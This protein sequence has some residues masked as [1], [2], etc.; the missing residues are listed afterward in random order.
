M[1]KRIAGVG[2]LALLGALAGGQGV[3]RS[4]SG[5]EASWSI[6]P[7]HV[8][9]W[10]SS[11]YIP[12]GLHIGGFEPEIAAAAAAGIQDV[13][14]DCPPDPAR[15]KAIVA[16]LEQK[17]LRYLIS[18][19]S[20]S[21]SA[22]GVLIEPSGNRVT[23]ITSKRT[24]EFRLPG[25]EEA[26]VV[27]AVRRD[28]FIQNTQRVR[29]VK[30][31][32]SVVVDPPNDLDHVALIYPITSSL[33]RLGAWEDF[34][35]HRDAVLTS[36]K[37]AGLGKGLRGIV[38]PVGSFTHPVGP[39]GFVPTGPLFRFEF[40]AY[41]KQRYR[42]P[43]TAMRSWAMAGTEEKTFDQIARLV[44]LW[45]GDRGV[46]SLWDP[47]DDKMY[48]CEMRRSSIWRDLDVVLS[49]A[50]A[51]RAERLIASIRRIADV[52]ILQEWSG[53]AP[54][55]EGAPHGLDGIGTYAAGAT[56]SAVAD[57]CSRAASSLLRW[58]KP[59]WLLATNLDLAG[60]PDRAALAPAAVDDLISIGVRGGF[61][62]TTEPAV[63]SVMAQIAAAKAADASLAQYTVRPFYFPEAATN[64]ALPMRLPGGSWWLPTPTAG[65]RI[66]LGSQ[67]YAYRMD[68]PSGNVLALWMQS[69]RARVKLDMVAPDN[70]LFQAVDGSDPKPKK[71]RG[72][73][74]VDVGELPLIVSGIDEIP[75]PSA[76]Y[77]ELLERFGLLIEEADRRHVDTTEERFLFRD[78]L[79]GY[80]RNP[81]GSYLLLSG[82]YQ[83]LA[84]RL[85]PYN[86]I[87]GES[88]RET[89]F[90]EIVAIPGISNGNALALRTQ[91][92]SAQ[93]E[94]TADYII[95]PRTDAEVEC[96]IAARIPPSARNQLRLVIGGQTMQ[97]EGEPVSGYG[98][99]FAWYSLGK[100]R[101]GKAQIKVSL[102]VR[103]PEGADLAIDAI[104]FY[105]G[106]FRPQGD[107][108]PNAI[109]FP[110]GG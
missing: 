98:P 39:R 18:I 58:T 44:P 41:L 57:S 14:V 37:S 46:S 80:S 21:P 33:A 23:G 79:N 81:G 56:P 35:R 49:T 99:G 97:V 60:A 26:L 8:L 34:D 17:N 68:T 110:T 54:L 48:A 65:T 90:S 108:P 104:L 16:S 107:R 88:V 31:D 55:Y 11:P 25:A 71:V 2:F 78:H 75:I 106:A 61:V 66:D 10:N 4:T 45:S 32:F 93:S 52:P 47:Q 53:W 109:A 7:N 85:A 89:N 86:W 63:K 64:P 83:K 15:M 72:G 38:N 76:A 20:L 22:H 13:L 87:E 1:V 6:N 40:A 59:G 96:W 92:L 69:G 3:Y 24:L 94:Y 5:E 29:S 62:R 19:D 70:A 84:Q 50:E 105:P 28:G 74:E 27:L 9:I 77:A 36:L 51:R 12:F 30:G 101:L 102:R 73:I 103:A 43:Q 91:L 95:Q 100:T 42:N 82:V 67:F